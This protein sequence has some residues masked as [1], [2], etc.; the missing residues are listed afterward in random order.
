MAKH[1]YRL[2]PCPSDDIRRTES[3]LEH[4]A[5]QSLVPDK[6]STRTRLIRF[7]PE[8]SQ[9]LR[10][11]LEPSDGGNEPANEMLELAQAF[12]W[13]YK[14]QYE[15]LFVYCSN[16]PAA[17]ELNTD[18]AVQALSLKYL[19]KKVRNRFLFAGGYLLF[20]GMLLLPGFGYHMVIFG[21]LCLISLL[22]MLTIGFAEQCVS[23]WRLFRLRKQL[24]A[25]I[26]SD[27]SSWRKGAKLYRIGIIVQHLLLVCL[28]LGWIGYAVRHLGFYEKPLAQYPGTPPFVT[29]DM[30]QADANTS[31]QRI[32]NSHYEAWSDPLF[33]TCI[34]W[35]DGG[36][37]QYGDED[38]YGGL[39]EVQYCHT[40]SPWLAKSIAQGYMRANGAADPL[41][42]EDLSMDYAAT[43]TS[44]HGF[45]MAVLAEGKT[46]V[47]VRMSMDDPEGIF[48]ME[49]WL[50][51]TAE[52]IK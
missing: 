44:R 1:V 29:L 30:L 32:D 7:R 37:I 9:A 39:L 13:E 34:T 27:P 19:H 23:L 22:T 14:G 36:S 48:T 15:G 45:P 25:G 2:P 31:V 16:D 21:S 4:M 33:P 46:V 11:R 49:N 8:E 6:W 43:F 47:C 26:E 52:M 41:L 17:R 51:Q 35:L 10:Y 18:P 42:R 28:L 20:L 3:W 5:A 38:I 50:R 40:L 12:G 24:L